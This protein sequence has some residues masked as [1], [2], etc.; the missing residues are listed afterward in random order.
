MNAQCTHMSTVC[1]CVDMK[2]IIETPS[3][4]IE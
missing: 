4:V 3:S 1:N 2:V